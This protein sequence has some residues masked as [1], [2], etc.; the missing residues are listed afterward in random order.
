MTEAITLRVGQVWVPGE[1]SRAQRRQIT[2]AGT[3]VGEWFR[4]VETTIAFLLL[5]QPGPDHIHHGRKQHG[6]VAYDNRV[7]EP[8]F[9]RWVI[10]HNAQLQPETS[11][12]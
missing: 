8:A 9:W 2:F 7:P 6:S 12:V 10:K 5:D 1:G 11:D 3:W 4:K